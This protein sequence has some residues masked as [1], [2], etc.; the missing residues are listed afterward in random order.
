MDKIKRSAL[1]LYNEKIRNP[2]SR[3]S[4]RCCD[5]KL[6]EEKCSNYKK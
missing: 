6:L 1:K 4:L 5:F 2:K 3:I